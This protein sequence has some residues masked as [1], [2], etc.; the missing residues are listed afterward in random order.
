MPASNALRRPR[1]PGVVGRNQQQDM[2]ALLEQWAKLR[3][4]TLH[5]GQALAWQA[6]H[7]DH[8]EV[9][10]IFAGTG[11]GK[12]LALDTPIATPSGWTTMGAL[13]VG[14]TVFDEQGQPC[15]V[16]YATPV[17]HDRTCYDVVLSDGT[18]IT[19]DAEH[20]WHTWT[21][22]ERKAAARR[23]DR[24]AKRRLAPQTTPR[25][26]A[27]QVR[28]TEEL[29]ASLRH[30]IGG[31]ERANHSIVVAA[32]L[33]LP[34]QPLPID[35]YVL[36]VWLGDGTG[37]DAVVTNVD[38]EVLAEVE[39]A[40]YAVALASERRE[41][42]APQY[43]VGGQPTQRDPLTGRM[44]ANGSLKS[45]LA[46]EGLLHN[47]HVPVAYLRA[48]AAQ[49]L[50]LLQGLMDTDGYVAQDGGCTFDNTNERLAEAVYELVV[51][52]GYKASRTTKRAMLNGQD[53][54]PCHRVI[55]TPD[56]PVFRLPRK[57][58]RQH[59]GITRATQQRHY[60]VDIRQRASVPVR[61][62]TVDSPSHLYLAGR[63]MVPTHNTW[64]GPRILYPIIRE[65]L[66]KVYL[67]TEPTWRMVKRVMIPEVVPFLNSFQMGEMHYGDMIYY[68]RGGG[69]ILFGSVDNPNSL[70]GAHVNGAVWNDEVG[71]DTEEAYDVTMQRRALWRAPVL[72]TSTPYTMPWVER[73]LSVP[74]QPGHPDS[75]IY[76]LIQFPSYWNPQYSTDEYLRLKRTWPADKFD[77]LMRGLFT[78]VGGLMF[79]EFSAERNVAVIY[80]DP[81]G[82]RL[83]L[84]HPKEGER[85][86]DLEQ[87]WLA[88]DWGWTD[89]GCQLLLASDAQRRVYV[90]EEDYGSGVQFALSDAYQGDTWTTRA[91][92]R[93]RAWGLDGVYAGHDRPEHIA[94]WQ[95]IGLPAVKATN[96]IAYGADMVNQQMLQRPD[97]TAGLYIA[98]NRC[99]NL[100]RTIGTYVRAK[101]PGSDS[102]LPSPAP[103]QEDHAVDCLR[104]GI[105]RDGKPQRP[106]G[107]GADITIWPGRRKGT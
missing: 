91:L 38:A 85:W 45:L 65:G 54:G 90:L 39:R 84:K 12:A 11:G 94:T 22:I 83:W 75:H 77:R 26:P 55:F 73:R 80:A 58:E 16:T 78:R 76:K 56:G 89:A 25:V 42:Y 71:Q 105:A 52:L 72:N 4:F 2:G 18:V 99:P 27:G 29:R 88:Q 34:E 100:V 97:G 37:A 23:I 8:Y 68:L 102:Y 67:F 87:V 30:T 93:M 69:R 20:R 10:S 57:L 13:Q 107:G 7:R 24:P 1:A 64:L 17:Q 48:S 74:S 61:C 59:L 35:P 14:D 19:A 104:Y 6:L 36:G 33:Q 44:Q 47:K 41:G 70:Q 62:I 63:A 9:L 50:A 66:D 15:Q 79:E 32:P 49:R 101:A 81:K 96:N 86:V 28:T 106:G 5:Y 51:S 31:V 95:Q 53:F 98:G 43:R 40:G 82:R 60:I 46:A 92:R 3:R 103:N 21:H